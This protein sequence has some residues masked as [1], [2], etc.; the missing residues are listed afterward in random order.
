MKRTKQYRAQ[1]RVVMKRREAEQM[2]RPKRFEWCGRVDKRPGS[3][4]LG[5]YKKKTIW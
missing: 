2:N 4:Q 5:L 1:R 3:T